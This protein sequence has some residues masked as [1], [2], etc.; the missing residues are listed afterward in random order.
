MV[1]RVAFLGTFVIFFL[2]GW[3]LLGVAVPNHYLGIRTADTLH[4]A[5]YWL[6]ANQ[7]GGWFLIFYAWIVVFFAANKRLIGLGWVLFVISAVCLGLVVIAAFPALANLAHAWLVNWG[8]QFGVPT[9][10][11]IS[12]LFALMVIGAIGNILRYQVI[13]INNYFGFRL[14]A[15]MA[16]EQLWKKGNQVGGHCLHSGMALATFG[17][18]LVWFAG[19][20]RAALVIGIFALTILPVFAYVMVMRRVIGVKGR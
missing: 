5:S 10:A 15:L 11:I 9:N 4:N 20:F 16:D 19:Y 8:L 1:A 14:A 3:L 7:F 18:S 12:L 6:S 13:P 17:V 2:L